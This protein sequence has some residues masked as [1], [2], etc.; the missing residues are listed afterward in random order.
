RGC[1]TR[2]DH[3]PAENAAQQRPVATTGTRQH[4]GLLPDRGRQQTSGGRGRR[5]DPQR[6][7]GQEHGQQGDGIPTPPHGGKLLPGACQER[8]D[9]R[10][11]EGHTHAVCGADRGDEPGGFH[12]HAIILSSNESRR[13]ASS[14]AEMEDPDHVQL[15]EPVAMDAEAEGRCQRAESR[16]RESGDRVRHLRSAGSAA[17]HLPRPQG[18]A[19]PADLRRASAVGARETAASNAPRAPAA[20]TV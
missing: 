3:A 12:G 9:W 13:G 15:P 17:G 14:N 16:Q 5:R 20:S 7:G 18:D 4:M 2:G 8:P 6:G 11:G 1:H 19:G 10:R